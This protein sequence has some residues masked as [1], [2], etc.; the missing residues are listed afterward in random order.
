[1]GVIEPTLPGGFKDYLPEDMIPRQKLFDA[2]KTVFERFGFVPLDTPCVE[3]AEILT[4]GDSE[5]QKQIFYVSQPGG[6]EEA[7]ALRFDL[8]VPLARV[9]AAYGDK[10]QRPF[11]RYQIGRLWRGERQQAGRYREF[12]QCD[13][14][15]VGVADM[16]ADAEIVALI[17]ALMIQL[18]FKN[19]LIRVNNRKILNGLAQYAS[20]DEEK[21]IS[22]IRILDKLDKQPWKEIDEELREKLELSETSV[23][24]IKEFISCAEGNQTGTLESLK[25]LFG[26]VVIAEE[27]IQ[28]LVEICE[29]LDAMGVSR[30]SWK[31]DP[32]VA[33]GLGY[34]TGPV[35][36]T[37]LLDLKEIGSV[38][39]GGR[40]DGLVSR[41]S[42]QNVPAVGA[43]LG[44]DRLYSAMETLKLIEKKKSPVQALVLNFEEQAKDRVLQIVSFLRNKGIN[45]ILYLGQENTLKGQLSFAVKE[46]IPF[47]VIV[48]EEELKEN[49][50]VVK[51]LSTREQTK[52]TLDE[53]VE[54]I[55]KE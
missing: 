41:F 51:N 21:T 4:G 14:D 5:F 9:V 45:S 11:R 46:E 55:I 32:S 26:G 7:T 53:C 34:Y 19:F 28:E 13:A 54:R 22:V 6:K 3:R 15:I 42:K 43:S 29:Y 27:G 2:I 50:V 44:I 12:A 23:E 37:Q 25:K 24:K 16:R 17:N 33:R 18:G 20:F 48:G 36:E 30:D 38:F 49:L 40:Y 47:V 31:I 1:M 10:I 39:S 8:T 52:G 35:F